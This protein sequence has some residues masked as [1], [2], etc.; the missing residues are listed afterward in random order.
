MDIFTPHIS[1]SPRK[2][3]YFRSSGRIFDGIIQ[4][5]GYDIRGRRTYKRNEKGEIVD[6]E[7]RV[8]DY[9]TDRK[10]NKIK[11]DPKLIELKGALDTDIPKVLAEW[12]K[13][14]KEFKSYL[15]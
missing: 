9:L 15:W 3:L 6:N 12:T 5:I 8:I 4:K 14:K 13:F 11:Q 1:L 2:N 7:G 10:G